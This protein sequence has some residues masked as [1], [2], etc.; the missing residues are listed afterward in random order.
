MVRRTGGYALN[1]GF[2]AD[3]E[4]MFRLALLTGFCY[5]NR[6][7]VWFDRSPG[8]DRHLGLSKEWDK[9]EFVLQ[10]SKVRLEGFLRLSDSLPPK[11]RKLIQEHLST[12]FSGLANWHLE[13][14]QY[15]K[16]RAAMSRAAQLDLTFNIGMKWLLTWISP[17]LALRTVR[18]RQTKKKHLYP[19]I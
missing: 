8:E 10:E 1:L 17:Q 15:G 11:V 6:P 19:A 16:A 5:V 13:T 18:N 4:F 7:L 14:G 2:Y 3:S 12:V 9:W